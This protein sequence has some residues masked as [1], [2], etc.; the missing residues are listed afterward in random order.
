MNMKI[1]IRV[2]VL[3]IAGGAIVAGAV[4][5]K[6]GQ[7][8]DLGDQMRVEAEAAVLEAVDPA[9]REYVSGL[10]AWAHPE[11]YDAAFTPEGLTG[12]TADQRTYQARLLDLII[13]R[14]QQDGQDSIAA[15]LADWRAAA[16][17]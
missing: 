6:A 7:K 11:A 14:A 17:V 4:L 12:G 8:S 16:G 15:A 13:Q 2:V 1:L 9:A 3:L 10:V 5:Y